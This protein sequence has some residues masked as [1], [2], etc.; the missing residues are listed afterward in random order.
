MKFNTPFHV[1]DSVIYDADNKKVKLWGVNYYT[2]FNHN[3][4]N[5]AELGKDHFK[6]I[7]EDIRNFKMMGIDLV[8]MHL[9]EREITDRYGNIVEN[10]NM[11]VFDYLVDQCE[12][13]GIFLMLAPVCWWN[14]IN[15]QIMQER[16]YA[17]WYIDSQEAFGFSNFYSCDS[18]LWD[19]EAIECQQRYMDGLFSRSSSVSGKRLPEYS[20]IVVLELF[21]EPRYPE[22][23][24]IK[25][26]PD[27]SD[28]SMSSATFSRGRQRQKL[29][30]MWENFKQDKNAGNE[31]KLFSEFRAEILKNYFAK[32]FP[33]IDKYFGPNVIKAQ[34]S[35]YCGIPPADLTKTFESAGIDAYTIGTYLNINKFDAENTN[36]ANHLACAKEWFDKLGD[37]DFGR[38]AKISYEF[39]ATATQN[40]YPLAAIAAMYA[41]YDV[42]IAA[43][44]TYTPS[45]VAAWNPGW[46]VHYTNIAHTP[47]RAAGFAAAGDIFRN[48]EPEDSIDMMENSWHGSDYSIERENDFVYFKNEKVFRYSNSND[49]HIT[50]VSKLTTVSGRGTSLFASSSGNGYY[51][52]EKKADSEWILA[53]FPSQQYVSAPERGKAYK[54]M[55]NRYVNCLKE[56]AVSILKEDKIRFKLNMLCIESAKNSVTG[57]SVA[58]ERD[59]SIVI[60][61]GE[62]TLKVKA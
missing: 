44:F 32:L 14:T 18:M 16:F 19:T 22:K 17:Y 31:D 6:A 12:K 40:G 45:A 8:R 27:P 1:K 4:Y 15:N 54:V 37:A 21:N 35:S 56:A 33:I 26:E 57:E 46:L 36:S 52:I 48:H 5:I 2:P 62:Y 7:D 42:Q 28:G 10:H 51:L 47:S 41:K 34:F 53:V 39:N 23:W 11:K 3:Y 55:A 59:G 43:L 9:Y 60:N 61:P 58:V 30:T 29:V 13:N 38:F 50:D 25:E 20:N 49:V 24:Q